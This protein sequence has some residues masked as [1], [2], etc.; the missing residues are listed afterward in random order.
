MRKNFLKGKKI[1]ITAYE[2]EQKEHRGISSVTKSLI[3]LLNKYGADIFLITGLDTKRKKGRGLIFKENQLSVE[4]AIAD[5]CDQLNLGVDYRKNF[6]LSNKYKIK[7]TFDLCLQTFLLIINNFRFR[8]K[9]YNFTNN[10]NLI[11]NLNTRMDYLNDVKGFISIK[12]IFHICRLRSMRLLART[13]KL[14]IN[15]IDLI[16]STSPLSIENSK[17][18]SSKLTQIVHDLIPIQVSSHPENPYIFYNRIKDSLTNKCIYVS[19]ESKRVI[20]KT[21]KINNYNYDN[22]VILNPLPSLN[23]KILKKA[24]EIKYLNNI[25]KPFILFNSSIVERK[26]VE[27]AIKYFKSSNLSNRGVLFCIAGK[28]HE[29]KYCEFIKNICRENDNIL[30]LDYVSDLEK[31]WLFLNSSLLISTSCIEGFGIPLLDALSINLPIL[32]TAIPSH[33]EIS[34]IKKNKKTNLINKKNQKFWLD[35]LNK[36]ELTDINSKDIKSLRIRSFKQ[37]IMN[38]ENNSIK[39]INSFIN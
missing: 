14:K 36:I 2:L 28:L 20:E 8:Y 29:N 1:A 3:K 12:Y 16:I 13:P 7:L 15:N 11:N 26:K 4:L 23:L 21:I 31:A 22:S 27:D 30:L 33:I 5:I 24:S 34:K 38:I 25:N 18:S 9:L 10:H 32:A 19:S 39:K 37:F 35:Y 6:K 17:S